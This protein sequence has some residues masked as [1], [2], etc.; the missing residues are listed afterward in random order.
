M[1]VL[2]GVETEISTN[3]ELHYLEQLYSRIHEDEA[4]EEIADVVELVE[5]HTGA[6]LRFNNG[7]TVGDALN[8]Q[9]R[10]IDW[11]VE[12]K[13]RYGLALVEGDGVREGFVDYI[14]N[15][16]HINAP[17]ATDR[18]CVL[19]AYLQWRDE[20]LGLCG[21]DRRRQ[22]GGYVPL[23]G[24]GIDQQPTVY[25][26]FEWVKRSCEWDYKG[27]ELSSRPDKGTCE[28]RIW[29]STW[30]KKVVTARIELCEQIGKTANGYV[31]GG[32]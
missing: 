10:V 11:M 12:N 29:D 32:L 7:M 14:G 21:T 31:K 6:E 19:M 13:D 28:I 5:E 26:K 22:G 18:E 27:P 25:D 24:H 2:V 30:D 15:H 1:N 20:V 3:M 8:A 17:T 23:F 9:L 16:H 4:V